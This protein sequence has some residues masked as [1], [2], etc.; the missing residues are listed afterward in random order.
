MMIAIM[1]KILFRKSDVKLSNNNN[2]CIRSHKIVVLY[3]SEN[4]I[5]FCIC[6][7]IYELHLKY[8]KKTV[9]NIM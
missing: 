9:S 5:A 3:C 8:E 2:C 1:R 4:L 6:P 7:I